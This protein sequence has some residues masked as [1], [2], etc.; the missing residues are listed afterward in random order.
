M[1]KTILRKAIKC[2][3]KFEFV[4]RKKWVTE[5]GGPENDALALDD[6]LLRRRVKAFVHMRKEDKN[7]HRIYGNRKVKIVPRTGVSKKSER[8][9]DASR[10]GN[11]RILD[12][13]SKMA[14]LH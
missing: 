4:I 13:W 8:Y 2:R 7:S 5:V 14:L 12:W 6:A 10:N 3:L 11:N 9:N 1:D